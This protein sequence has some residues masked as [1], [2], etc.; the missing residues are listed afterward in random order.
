MG[1]EFFAEDDNRTIRTTAVGD[2]DGVENPGDSSWLPLP[3]D[4]LQLVGG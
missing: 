3:G 1:D 4:L 2:A